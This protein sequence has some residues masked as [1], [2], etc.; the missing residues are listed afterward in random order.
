[1]K[2][3]VELEERGWQALSAGGE[4]AKEF[5]GSLL[6]DNAV[7]VFPGGMLIEGKEEILDS[8]DAQP[9]NS[10]QMEDLRVILAS[11]DVRVIVYEVAAKREGR[12]A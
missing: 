5:Y 8:L 10:F 9:W 12:E 11:E 3:L 1:M 6:A 7:M 4:A 2:D